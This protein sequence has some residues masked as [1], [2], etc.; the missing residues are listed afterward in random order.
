MVSRP[1][2]EVF[3]T[4]FSPLAAVVVFSSAPLEE[5]SDL[6]VEMVLGVVIWLVVSPLAASVLVNCQSPSSWLLVWVTRPLASK[7][8]S[9]RLPLGSV[10]AV[11]RPLLPLYSKRNDLLPG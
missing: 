5:F 11:S 1:S 2:S 4:V 7:K 10:L 9:K 8:C 6:I 3:L